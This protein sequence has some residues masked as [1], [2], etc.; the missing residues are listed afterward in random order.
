MPG[1]PNATDS[2]A[3]RR[4]AARRR[5]HEIAGRQIDIRGGALIIT[6]PPSLPPPTQPWASSP[7]SPAR[8]RRCSRATT[9]G[10]GEPP[11][12]APVPLPQLHNLAA[13]TAGPPKPRPAPPHHTPPPLV[14]HSLY[15][16]GMAPN[17]TKMEGASSVDTVKGVSE[18]QHAG[19]AR[20]PQR[21]TAYLHSASCMFA[22]LQCGCAQRSLQRRG[23]S[24]NLKHA[25]RGQHLLTLA[26]SRWGTPLQD[27]SKSVWDLVLDS[28]D[29]RRKSFESIDSGECAQHAARADSTPSSAHMQRTSRVQA[30]HTRAR[31]G[32]RCAPRLILGPLIS[33]R[34][35]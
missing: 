27:K 22:L 7:G 14:P 32:C 33:I 31:I 23:L 20:C 24:C 11:A 2:A 15:D 18:G 26:F 1:D 8:P 9:P 21:S 16:P 35:P 12:R 13:C 3:A 5:R 29:F 28:E 25:S 4:L 30:A 17:P 10:A 6:P 34:A 19:A